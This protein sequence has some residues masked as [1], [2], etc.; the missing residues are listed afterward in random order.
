MNRRN[1]LKLIGIG[2]AVLTAPVLSLLEEKFPDGV[3]A[4]EVNEF[5]FSRGLRPCQHS[6]CSS[7]E[8]F[9]KC[10]KNLCK[11]CG[12]KTDVHLID[13]SLRYGPE[14]DRTVCFSCNPRARVILKYWSSPWAH[15]AAQK[16]GIK[17]SLC[18]TGLGVVH[19]HGREFDYR[20]CYKC[21]PGSKECRRWVGGPTWN[22]VTLFRR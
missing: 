9:A 15:M 1:F 19:L 12:A 11:T 2:G 10:V 6:G 4:D 5:L 22:D 13:T 18:G 16:H 20:L 8:H 17:C 21:A 14:R 3:T 7:D